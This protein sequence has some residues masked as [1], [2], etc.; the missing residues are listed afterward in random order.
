MNLVH[1]LLG[2]Q[3]L[4]GAAGAGAGRV[5]SL[6]VLDAVITEFS[7]PSASEIGLPWEFHEK[8]RA[9]F[10]VCWDIGLSSCIKLLCTSHLWFDAQRDLRINGTLRERGGF[11]SPW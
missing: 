6:S 3:D 5:T 10:E 4:D 1:Q 11:K 9:S 8:C 2:M 7:P